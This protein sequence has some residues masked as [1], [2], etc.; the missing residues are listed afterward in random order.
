M[1]KLGYKEDRDILIEARWAENST[2][3]L[4]ALG[5]ELAALK[6]AVIVTGSSA[7]VAAC[8]KATSTIPIVFATASNPV[9]Q[10]FVASL[11]RPGGNVT[12]ILVHLD[13][14]GKIVEVAREAFP[15]AARV[16]TLVHEADPAHGRHLEAFIASTQRFSL[17][18]V[19]VRVKRREDLGRAF[20]TLAERK[21]DALILP[22]LVFTYTHRDEI[23]R[24]CLEARLPL[25]SSSHETTVAG[26]LLSYGTFFDDNWR[27]AA[28]F[29]HQILGGARPGDLPVE[30]PERVQLVVNLKTANAIGAK[31]SR[32]TM[33]RADKV[34][35]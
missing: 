23:V 22:D 12:G 35:E 24:R 8:R 15:G 17:E 21:T 11:R 28:V 25:F 4:E 34:I 31:L 1:A 33:L 14:A 7:G 26:G 3:R 29:V 32:A 27:R 18:P 30:Q 19:V 5:A 13:T 20:R 9:E 6:P 2:V 16:A 10:G